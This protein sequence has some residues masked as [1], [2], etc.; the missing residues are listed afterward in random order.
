MTDGFSVAQA[1]ADAARQAGSTD[2][3][4][5]RAEVQSGIVT[6]VAVTPG[7]VDVGTI[8]AR[9]L[10]SYQQ[11]TV[12][13]QVLLV[14]SGSG[15]W[16]AAGRPASSAAPLGVARWLWKTATQ[17]RFSNALT[18]D[19]DLTVQLDA[20]ATYHVEMHLHHAATDAVRFRTAWTVPAGATGN[21]SAMGPDQG[22]ILSSTST[23]GTGRWGVHGFTTACI[24][25]NRDSA[26]AQAYAHE[27]AIV[28]TVSAGTLALQWA[29]VTTSAT[30]AARLAA[31][32]SMRV[33]RLA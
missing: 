7:T 15:T 19:P 9:R 32:S 5:R 8:R 13:D 26:A 18:D 1:I 3:A 22:V 21:K 27:E 17:D 28:T 30:A 4:V 10:E 29:Q 11:P 31:G 25:G 20:N 16:W 24:Y 14:Q 12:G 33:T 6:A 23:G 2:P